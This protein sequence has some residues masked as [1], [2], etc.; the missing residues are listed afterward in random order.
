MISSRV[1]IDKAVFGVRELTRLE[2]FGQGDASRETP[3]I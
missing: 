3:F 2:Q 1:G